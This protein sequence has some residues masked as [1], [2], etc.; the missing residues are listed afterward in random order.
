MITLHA[1]ASALSVTGGLDD[2]AL[3]SG[4]ANVASVQ[5]T[6][7]EDWDNLDKVLVFT[8]GIKTII[9]EM[10]AEDEIVPIPHELMTGPGKTLYIGVQGTDG[11]RV[12]LPTV[13][14]RLKA[15]A[16]G[17]DP[18]GD[19][20]TVPS[21]VHWIEV[22]DELE[23]L[24]GE[25]AASEAAA[26]ASETAA[27]ASERN[28]AQSA[29]QAMITAQTITEAAIS[30]WLDGN[31]TALADAVVEA[32][33]TK[34]AT[35]ADMQADEA[36][37]AGQI[38]ATL[39]YTTLGDGGGCVYRISGTE[40]A[41]EHC[42]LLND[43]ALHGVRYA[44]MVPPTD[45]RPEMFGAVGNGVADDTDELHD[46][47]TY[48]IGHGK[49]LLLAGMHKITGP[50][51]KWADV[52]GAAKMSARY[53]VLNI[54][55]AR[56]DK[57]SVS[58]A[59]GLKYGGIRMQDGV[60]VFD[61]LAGELPWVDPESDDLPQPPLQLRGS[62]TRV[63]FVGQTE[64][65]NGS[66]FRNCELHAFRL[67]SCQISGIGAIFR[68]TSINTGS[69]IQNNTTTRLS[70]VAY[71]T[72]PV[73]PED[74][75]DPE[76]P[77]VTDFSPYTKG[78]RRFTIKDSFLIGN[79]FGGAGKN[80]SGGTAEIDT[81]CFEWYDWS[82]SEVANNFIEIFQSVFYPRY[83]KVKTEDNATYPFYGP[84]SAGNNYQMFKYLY[85]KEDT[86]N[87]CVF[88]SVGDQ[89]SIFDEAQFPEGWGQAPGEKNF[90]TYAR[91]IGANTYEVPQCLMDIRWNYQI[92]ITDAVIN[93]QS[94]NIVF[95]ENG[96]NYSSTAVQYPNACARLSIRLSQKSNVGNTYDVCV[97]H[98]DV[99]RTRAV[100]QMID[101]PFALTMTSLSEFEGFGDLTYTDQQ[102]GRTYHLYLGQRAICN[103]MTYRLVPDMAENRPVW[104]EETGTQAAAL[105]RGLRD[106]L[107]TAPAASIR[108][109]LATG[110]SRPEYRW[111]TAPFHERAVNRETQPQERG[112]I[113]AYKNWLNNNTAR[114]WMLTV[115]A[116]T[117]KL[118]ITIAGTTTYYALLQNAA[119]E[120][121]SPPNYCAG[122]EGRM[123]LADGENT[124]YLPMDCAVIY[125][126]VK[127]SSGSDV[128]PTDARWNIIG[129]AINTIPEAPATD[130]SYT[131][132]ATV[133]DGAIEYTWVAEEA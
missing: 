71:C 115:P 128:M 98:S 37:A 95:V 105:I 46:A 101:I 69:L 45:V 124:I 49:R 35:V 59:E 123:A 47:L 12:I 97:A 26:E 74:P 96:L 83:Y 21:K 7:S 92:S 29:Q 122:Y 43:S 51:L 78:G 70:S 19:T 67:D 27:A 23:R 34:Y 117:E 60:H 76:S 109:P 15:V 64:T 103:G 73:A 130:G 20:T 16:W 1:E 56:P 86:T 77:M 106:P 44:V 36:L 40:E 118:R 24:A 39:G 99:V 81:H 66:I 68:Y 85:Y 32:K 52:P 33:L 42:I 4:M 113:D 2:T 87:Y 55:G 3:V 41:G 133:S 13:M 102:T 129:E 132:R 120:N 104:V 11:E 100:P 89:F 80:S 114:S 22:R 121:Q 90:K 88:N 14:C 126:N 82:A 38:V 5:V 75:D 116:G 6:F 112:I 48:A 10:T 18:D 63:A 54:E 8:D 110:G 131:L 9:H 57:Y 65:H 91:T 30:D 125:V 61:G 94:A 17:P 62:I 58:V 31:P 111:I 127:T 53:L 119:V 79:Y 50:I 108:M 107:L 93:S 84:L 72:F 25:A 28:A